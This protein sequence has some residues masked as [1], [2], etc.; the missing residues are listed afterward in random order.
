[1]P[2]MYRGQNLRCSPG[3]GNPGCCFVTLYVGEVSEREQCHLLF[4]SFQLLSLLPII[5]SGTLV[6]I[7]R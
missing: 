6:L 7:P 2:V 5:K 3:Q 1:M 4:A